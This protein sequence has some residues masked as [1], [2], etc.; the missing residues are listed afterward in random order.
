MPKARKPKP[1]N[2][3]LIPDNNEAYKLLDTVRDKWHEDMYGAKIAL[4]YRK[5]LKRDKDGFL[6]LGRC[7]KVSDLQKEFIPFDF[8]IVLNRE[9]WTDISFDKKRK[10][11]LLDHEMCHASL[12]LDRDLERTTDEKGRT[13]YRTRRHDIEEFRSVVEHHGCYKADLEKFAES[14][15]KKRNTPLL[16][17]AM[18]K[19]AD[20]VNAG[21]LDKDGI[22]VTA[23]VH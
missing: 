5:R 12:S 23:K 6:M 10:L 8:I 2:Y 4:A 15:L 7:V 21:A 14:L 1:V 19:V 20:Q 17:E 11:A 22:T 9:V 18:E 16:M 3:D 13:V